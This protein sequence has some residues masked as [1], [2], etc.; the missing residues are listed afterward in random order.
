MRTELNKNS[1]EKTYPLEEALRAQKA[2]REMAG[3]GPEMFPMPAFVG[4]IS[5][6]IEV[7]RGRGHDDE[8]IARTITANSQIAIT[9]EEIA[10]YYAPADERH[11]ER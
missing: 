11:G 8:A 4:M 2:L 10:A 9:A 3:M 6:E 1:T 7:L 5:D